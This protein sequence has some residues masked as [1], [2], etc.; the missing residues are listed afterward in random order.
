MG[1]SCLS[2]DQV[3]LDP[4]RL[5]PNPPADPCSKCVPIV[6]T[7]FRRG[8]D[9]LVVKGNEH[10]LATLYVQLDPDPFSWTLSLRTGF[11]AP[12]E[13]VQELGFHAFG[14]LRAGSVAP[15]KLTLRWSKTPGLTLPLRRSGPA[16]YR[17]W[18]NRRCSGLPAPRLW[19]PPG[20]GDGS[21]SR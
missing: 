9:P 8:T 21:D 3:R 19:P 2:T 10:V 17:P 5:L 12:G 4:G 15:R 20:Y 13:Q 16:A 18:G 1:G 14:G 7:F 11:P 6:Q